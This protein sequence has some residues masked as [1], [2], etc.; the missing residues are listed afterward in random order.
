MGLPSTEIPASELWLHL[1]QLP[2]PS[3]EVDY[4][5]KDPVTGEPIGKLVMRVLSQQEQMAAATAAE[6]FTR[7]LIKDKPKGEESLGYENVYKNAAAIEVLYRACRAQ[8]D[9]AR[10]FF[11]SPKLMRDQLTAD[12]VGVLLAIY[13]QVQSELGPIVAHMEEGEMEAWV[14]RLVEGGSSF[15]LALLSSEGVTDLVML[16]ASR[17]LP[18]LT[19]TSSSG[20]QLDESTPQATS[21]EPSNDVEA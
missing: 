21:D 15:P 16:M 3:R 7:S 8:E 19:A 9:L 10:A 20:S 1:M 17:L 18:F 11:P 13:I 14:R 2:R 6:T 4:P 5:R 12:E